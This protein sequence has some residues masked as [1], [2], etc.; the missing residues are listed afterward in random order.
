MKQNKKKKGLE[1]E[2]K[3]KQTYID[4]SNHVIKTKCL[5]QIVRKILPTL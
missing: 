2:I 4:K 3:K 1:D 5:K